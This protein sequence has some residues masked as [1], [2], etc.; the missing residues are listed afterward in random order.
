VACADFVSVTIA[1][2]SGAPFKSVTR[3]WVAAKAPA[4]QASP[5]TMAAARTPVLF[6]V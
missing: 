3:P 5:I 4:A 6:I 2:A 1:W